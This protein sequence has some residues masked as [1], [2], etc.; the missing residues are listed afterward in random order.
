MTHSGG[1]PHT[2][3]GDVGQRYEVR[4]T[5]YPKDDESI[6][7]WSSTLKGAED[8]ALAIRQAPRCLSTEIIDRE[9]NVSIFKQ[10]AGILR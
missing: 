5:G 1:K 8:M 4:A 6:I 9:G 3:I 2:N 7:G 10:Y